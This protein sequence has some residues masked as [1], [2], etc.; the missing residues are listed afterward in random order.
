MERRR[1]GA[2]DLEIAPIVLGGNVFGWTADLR[3]SF[4]ILDRFIGRGFNAVDTADVYSNWVPGHVGGESEAVIGQWL[5]ARGRRERVVLATKVGA[6]PRGENGGRLLANLSAAHIVKSVE[7]SLRRLQT[8]YVDLYQSHLPDPGTP[9]D[10]TLEAYRRLMAS[11]KVRAIGA[12]NHGVADLRTAIETARAKDLPRYVCLQPLYNLVHR[13]AF[14][15][16]VQEFCVANDIGVLCYR[17]LAQGF[18]SG[19]Y[20]SEA[21]VARS[22][23]ADKGLRLCL[24]DPGRRVLRALDDIA[25]ETHATLAEI[26]LGWLLSRRG[27]TAPIVA[28]N[29]VAELDAMLGAV[30]VKLTTRQL[31]ALDLA[32][33][34]DRDSTR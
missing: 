2:S 15:G 34:V 13:T 4:D 14:E 6:L 31:E 20:R 5:K 33:G 18:L 7:A 29:N 21:D 10:E 3:T 27:L 28:V 30:D 25:E 11:G 24:N 23:W 19:K 8:D 22:E 16:D 1:I 32:S 9:I 12:S 26:S 17:G